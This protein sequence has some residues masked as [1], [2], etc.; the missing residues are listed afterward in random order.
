MDPAGGGLNRIHIV[1][2]AGSVLR[3]VPGRT[4]PGDKIEI[5]GQ[6]FID[7]VDY[8]IIRQPQTILREPDNSFGIGQILVKGA[9]F[10]TE[11][12]QKQASISSWN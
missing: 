5:T 8:I 2:D 10:R 12:L 3:V 4:D 7:Q 9:F 1:L 11:N 6:G